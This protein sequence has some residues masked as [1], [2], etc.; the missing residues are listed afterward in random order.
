M[1]RL[2]FDA[3]S[4]GYRLHGVPV[5]SVTG[6]LHRAGLIDFSHI[7]PTVLERARQRGTLVHDAVHLYNV[8]DL[9]VERFRADVPD[10]AGY[11]DGWVRFCAQRQFVP[12]VC[13]HR[14]A[15]ET[16][17]LAGTLDALGWL[18]DRPVL[19]D[20]A[21]GRPADVAKDLQTAAYAALVHDSIAVDDTLAAFIAD[22]RGV[23]ERYAVA[24]HRDAT[25]TLE[26]YRDPRD[27]R[28]FQI[29]LQAERIR[30]ARARSVS[31]D[32]ML[33]DL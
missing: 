12:V 28:T 3:P 5:P 24:L 10:C 16:W 25:F 26:H 13:E 21:T 29:L 15:S 32:A 14:V 9:D 22:A 20:F 8:G 2:T 6:V 7:P 18:D 4:H 17:H 11:L 27:V 30:E 33:A 19:L 31:L 23:I 1:A